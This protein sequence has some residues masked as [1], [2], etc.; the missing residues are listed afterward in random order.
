MHLNGGPKQ[1]F[2]FYPILEIIMFSIK[3]EATTQDIVI[4]KRKTWSTRH[5]TQDM[6]IN[7]RTTINTRHDHQHAQDMAMSWGPRRQCLGQEEMLW[8]RQDHV[9]GLRRQCFGQEE[10]MSCGREDNVLGS[11]RNA[12]GSARTCSGAEKAMFRGQEARSWGREDKMRE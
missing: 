1:L 4:N 7:T 5:K 2:C 3:F 8:G 6:I 12:L 9:L 11:R 10:E